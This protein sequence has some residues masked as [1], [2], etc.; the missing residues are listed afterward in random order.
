MQKHIDAALTSIDDNIEFMEKDGSNANRFFCADVVSN[1]KF[2]QNYGGY[3]RSEIAEIN[4]QANL[5]IQKSMLAQL[6]DFTNQPNPTEGMSDA[7]LMLSHRSKYQQA[8]SE[9]QSWLEGQLQIRDAQRVQAI[10]QMQAAAAA[11][12]SKQ[13]SK[14]AAPTVPVEPE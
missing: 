12:E 14:K 1:R 3:P 10:A 2:A 8:P 9:M 5:E 13:S 7:Q 11:K 6:V 4:A